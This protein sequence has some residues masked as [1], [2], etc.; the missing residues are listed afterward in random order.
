M[1]GA[2]PFEMIGRPPKLGDLVYSE[3]KRSIIGYRLATDRLYS[4]KDLA[5]LFQVSRAPV[6]EAMI[7]LSSEGLV[8]ILPNKGMRVVELDR[9]DIAECFQMRE[10]LET[11][12]VRHLVEVPS[13]ETVRTLR[14]NLRRQE[15]ILERGDLQGWVIQN[16]EFHMDLARCAGNERMSRALGSISEQVQRVGLALIP[17][18]R[19]MRDAYN[20]H[21]EIVEAICNGDAA[22]AERE[23]LRHLGR[24]A[25]LYQKLRSSDPTSLYITEETSNDHH[26]SDR[27]IDS[28]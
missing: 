25:D 21:C 3:I 13:A 23:V 19:P 10:A 2:N 27:T 4:E 8:E 1:S 18:A 20:E 16:F 7:R 24:N 28:R 15:E 6:R 22:A 17:R 11:W 14:A 26:E 12:I 5:E 9:T